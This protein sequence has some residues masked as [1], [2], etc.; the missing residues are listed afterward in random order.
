MDTNL[1]QH[2]I[3]FEQRIWATEA[4]T[5][6]GFKDVV[7]C[8]NTWF[9]ANTA[10]KD[11]GTVMRPDVIA[12][13]ERKREDAEDGRVHVARDQI[14]ADAQHRHNKSQESKASRKILSQ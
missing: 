3:Q 10:R 4:I 1:E 5:G 12:P 13:D 11:C 8:A 9:I 2:I 7:H 6:F 14:R